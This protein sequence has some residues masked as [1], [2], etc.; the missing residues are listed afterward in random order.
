MQKGN[1]NDWQ[2]RIGEKKH[3]CFVLLFFWRDDQVQSIKRQDGRS[4]NELVAPWEPSTWCK[5][6][7]PLQLRSFVQGKYL[8][9]KYSI[10][11]SFLCIRSNKIILSGLKIY[12]FVKGTCREG[13]KQKLQDSKGFNTNILTTSGILTS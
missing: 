13:R 3:F 9:K 4:A 6:V 11:H 8:S 7:T 1:K 12:E 10:I 5:W 2:K